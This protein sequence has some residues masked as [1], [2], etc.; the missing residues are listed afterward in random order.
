MKSESII[1]YNR[2]RPSLREQKTKEKGQRVCRVFQGLTITHSA[3]G[4][5]TIFILLLSCVEKMRA[6]SER[7][8]E[9]EN[10]REIFGLC[11]GTVG[12]IGDGIIPRLASLHHPPVSQKNRNWPE[13]RVAPPVGLNHDDC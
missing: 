3:A 7:E 6:S 4:L 8:R 12:S 13:F 10:G 11:I 5:R 1:Y 9:R 2:K